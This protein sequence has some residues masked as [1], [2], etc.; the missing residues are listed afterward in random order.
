MSALTNIDNMIR[1]YSEEIVEALCQR[2]FDDAI[3]AIATLSLLAGQEV[4]VPDLMLRLAGYHPLEVGEDFVT[5]VGEK[6]YR[7][8]RLVGTTRTDVEGPDA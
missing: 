7:L 3:T 6:R 8:T 1:G 2:R 4:S 5:C